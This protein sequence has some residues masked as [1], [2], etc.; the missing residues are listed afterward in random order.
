MWIEHRAGF[1]FGPAPGTVLRVRG[2][3]YPEF[4]QLAHGRRCLEI[5]VSVDGEPRGKLTLEASGPFEVELDLGALPARGRAVLELVPNGWFVPKAIG[6][7]YDSR[8]LSVQI[9][10]IDLGGVRLF[11][12]S[13]FGALE[14]AATTAPPGVNLIGYA[15]SPTGLGQGLRQA[16][17]A[18]DWAGIPLTVIDFP[19]DHPNSFVELSLEGRIAAEPAHGINIV[20]INAEQM[21][22]AEAR[23]PSLFAGRFNIGYWAWELPEMPDSHLNGFRCL[24]EVWVP[25]SF[26]QDAVSKKSPCPV[27]RMPHSIRFAPS[28]AASR[29][30]FGLPAN[31][32]LFLLMYDFSSVQARKN[33]IAALDAFERAFPAADAPAAVVIKTQNARLHRAESEEL[34]ARIRGRDHFIW[35]DVTLPRQDAHDLMAV[36]DALVSLHRS[37]GFGLG[38]AEAM[39]LGRPVI[40]TN[41]SGNTDF[42]RPDNSL[43]VDYQLVRIQRDVGAFSAGQMWAEPDVEHAAWLLRRIVEDE[44]W[45]ARISRQAAQTIREDYSPERIGQR[46]RARLEYIQRNLLG[47]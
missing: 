18:L 24:D 12:P 39:Y 27:V 35:L 5:L 22:G 10:A 32:F 36:C 33:P 29:R 28:A 8:T 45:R 47:R 31:R 16:A 17:D 42:M 6:L 20:H 2:F 3:H 46:A 30:S 13:C 21:P 40:A 38:P 23:T 1:L 4:R 9:A 41:W 37:E 7:N 43:P 14:P 34:S 26:V 44:P 25:S 11:D 15:R 19:T